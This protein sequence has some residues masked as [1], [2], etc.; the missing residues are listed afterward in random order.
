[1][2]FKKIGIVDLTNDKFR[3]RR[4][5]P[6]FSMARLTYGS[7]ARLF[8]PAHSGEAGLRKDLREDDRVQRK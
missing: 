2:E 1:L 3:L 7:A 8:G 6:E 4:A 5:K